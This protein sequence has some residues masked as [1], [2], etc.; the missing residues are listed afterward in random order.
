V[1]SWNIGGAPMVGRFVT[2][3]SLGVSWL[4]S[5]KNIKVCKKDNK[6][7]KIF[8]YSINS[9]FHKKLH[10]DQVLPKVCEWS[11]GLR[12]MYLVRTLIKQVF[13]YA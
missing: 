12:M 5:I 8:T 1:R 13:C 6:T 11:K 4:L 7:K 9:E 3:E 2:L 10:K